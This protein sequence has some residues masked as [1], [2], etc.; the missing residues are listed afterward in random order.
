[1]TNLKHQ[2]VMRMYSNRIF[3]KKKILYACICCV[4]MRLLLIVKISKVVYPVYL[5]GLFDL[6]FNNEKKE[7]VYPLD[8]SSFNRSGID[9]SISS[10]S[11]SQAPH[12]MMRASAR[13]NPKSASLSAQQ[14]V[15]K[16]QEKL[17]CVLIFH[18][19]L[20]VKSHLYL[21]RYKLSRNLNTDFVLKKKFFR[22]LRSRKSSAAVPPSPN[23]NTG[24]IRVYSSQHHSSTAK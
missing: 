10:N 22:N 24:S 8:L 5:K 12:H 3:F 6:F 18:L 13:E 17:K 4:C 20:F 19:N 2:L 15:S 23:S 11:T 7:L 16:I 14:Q 1:M 21:I 9:P